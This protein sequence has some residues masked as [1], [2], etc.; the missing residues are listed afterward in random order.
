MLA[1]PHQIWVVMEIN[2]PMISTLFSDLILVA[3]E[4]LTNTGYFFESLKNKDVTQR[5][6]EIVG[7]Y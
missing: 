7:W 2:S 6:K 5:K 1:E 3:A 4:L